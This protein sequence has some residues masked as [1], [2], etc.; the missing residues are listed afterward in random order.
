MSQDPSNWVGRV[1]GW[2]F[3][4][5]AAAI[6]LS[7]AVKIIVSVWPTLAAIAGIVALLALIYGVV[8]YYTSHKF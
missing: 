2:C 8:V 6:A 5:L 3:R 4:I 7:C 1:T